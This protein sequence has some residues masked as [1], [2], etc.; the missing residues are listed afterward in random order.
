[1]AR[2]SQLTSDISYTICHSSRFISEN[3]FHTSQFTSHIPY[4]SYLIS[5][6]SYITHHFS[7]VIFLFCH[8]SRV[9]SLF[10]YFQCHLSYTMFHHSYINFVESDSSQD[11]TQNRCNASMCLIGIMH[12]CIWH[13]MYNT[14]IA[15]TFKA[16]TVCVL[17][18]CWW[19]DGE[20]EGGQVGPYVYTS[21]HVC[22][23]ATRC[24]YMY[25]CMYQYMHM[26]W[27]MSAYMCIYIY[28]YIYPYLYIY[29]YIYRYRYI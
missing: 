24:T 16:C 10:S 29:T 23:S 4:L 15:R 7:Y 13:C 19:V 27:F 20:K 18:S 11:H 12:I 1:M 8:I 14:A 9:T 6:I 5:R 25:L 22:T 2:I 21:V 3:R 26:C 28:I 17:A